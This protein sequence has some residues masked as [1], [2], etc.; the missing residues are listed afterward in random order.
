MLIFFVALIGALELIIRAFAWVIVISAI[1][2]TV[3]FV[4]LGALFGGGR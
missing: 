2:L 1:G 4:A 3:L